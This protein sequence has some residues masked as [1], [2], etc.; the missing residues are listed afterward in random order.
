[1]RLVKGSASVWTTA[2]HIINPCVAQM[3]SCTRTIVSSIGPPVSKGSGSPFCTARS[4]STKVRAEQ[5]VLISATTNFSGEL[6]SFSHLWLNLGYLLPTMTKTFNG[7]K[8]KQFYNNEWVSIITSLD[9]ISAVASYNTYLLKHQYIIYI[10]Y[11]IIGIKPKNFSCRAACQAQAG[12]GTPVLIFPR[13]R[14]NVRIDWNLIILGLCKQGLSFV[15]WDIREV[16]LT[17][18]LTFCSKAKGNNCKLFTDNIF[19]IFMSESLH[20]LHRLTLHQ[21]EDLIWIP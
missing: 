18:T 21:H 15:K 6:D 14:T 11:Y 20:K 4:A 5:C 12:G 19:I 3:E 13:S 10:I 9:L 16:R 8:L 17:D 1:M 2:S 7:A